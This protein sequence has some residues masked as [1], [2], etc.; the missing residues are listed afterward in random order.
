MMANHKKLEGKP[1]EALRGPGPEDQPECPDLIS[2]S[3]DSTPQK[4]TSIFRK[5]FL[6]AKETVGLKPNPMQICKYH[7]KDRWF[8]VNSNTLYFVYHGWNVC[9]NSTVLCLLGGWP[10]KEE[11]INHTADV[12]ELE[13]KPKQNEDLTDC[14][15]AEKKNVGGR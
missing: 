5:G 10:V 7:G 15:E 2:P 13:Y 11:D 12:F 3:V 9:G 6:R 8:S 1:F 14:V 4:K